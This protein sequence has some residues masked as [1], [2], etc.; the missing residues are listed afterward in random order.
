MVNPYAYTYMIAARL[1]RSFRARPQE[2]RVL[3]KLR[4]PI[5]ET[6]ESRQ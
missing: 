3:P 5:P 4:A 2:D 6:P 1:D